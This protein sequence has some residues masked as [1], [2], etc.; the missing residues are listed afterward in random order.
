VYSSQPVQSIDELTQL[1]KNN[2]NKNEFRITYRTALEFRMNAKKLELMDDFRVSEKV[3]FEILNVTFYL[4][5]VK[6]H[7]QHTSHILRIRF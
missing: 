2:D 3:F 5:S 4:T 1:T 7:I 6:Y